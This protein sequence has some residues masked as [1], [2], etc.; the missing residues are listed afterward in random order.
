M[1]LPFFL[2]IMISLCRTGNRSFFVSYFHLLVAK[3]GVKRYRRSSSLNNSKIHLA[4][5][6]TYLPLS[7]LEQMVFWTLSSL[8]IMSTFVD[9]DCLY[10]NKNDF[11]EGD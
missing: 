6:Q 2:D 7:G 3:D 5:N 4:K 11:P 9:G 1:T 8:R 10:K